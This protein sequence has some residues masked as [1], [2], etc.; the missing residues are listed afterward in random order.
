MGLTG[1]SKLQTKKDWQLKVELVDDSALKWKHPRGYGWGTDNVC[2]IS[3]SSAKKKVRKLFF[4]GGGG[5]DFNKRIPISISNRYAYVFKYVVRLYFSHKVS[6]KGSGMHY[7]N[8]GS[9]TLVLHYMQTS[10]LR[11]ELSKA[12][13]GKH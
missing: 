3:L 12:E 7:L 10:V 9:E 13:G 2:H 8:M 6:L 1:Q 11:K 4:F 5:Y